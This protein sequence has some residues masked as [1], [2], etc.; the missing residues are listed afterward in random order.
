[1]THNNTDKRGAAESRSLLSELL[2]QLYVSPLRIVIVLTCA[3]MSA[4][5]IG[6]AIFFQF[7]NLSKIE[8]FII[9]VILVVVLLIPA[10]LLFVFKPLVRHKS[11]R[12]QAADDLRESERLLQQIMDFL[13]VGVWIF[14]RQGTVIRANPECSRIWGEVRMVGVD[15]YPE[16]KAWWPE[17]GRL[18][19]PHEWG[20][21]SALQGVASSTNQ[22]I[23]IETFDGKRKTMLNSAT[24][25]KDENGFIIGAVAVINDITE[26]RQ[27]NEQIRKLSQAVEQSPSSIIIT[28][29]KGQIEYANPA[30]TLLTGY[31]NREIIGTTPHILSRDQAS[32]RQYQTIWNAIISGQVWHGEFLNRKKDGSTYWEEVSIAPIASSDG[33]ITHYVAVMEDITRR[34]QAEVELLSSRKRLRALMS[35]LEKAREEERTRIAREVH[36]ELGQ[37]LASVQMGISLLAQEYQ[38]HHALTERITSMEEMLQGAIRSVRQIA[39]EL[40]PM[41]LDTLGLGEAIDWQAREFQKK[42]GIACKP[43]INLKSTKFDRDIS[44]ALFRIFQETLTNII[45]H[46]G[47]TYVGVTLEERKDRLVL[48]VQDN[49][50]GITPKQLKNGSS[51]GIMGMRERAYSLG[52]RVRIVGA[53]RKGTVVIAHIPAVLPGEV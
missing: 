10:L 44:T 12:Q 53:P 30:F 18:L 39:T 40:R 46:S 25:I 31:E 32:Y 33:T 28:D 3:V 26:L 14:D 17:S 1:M 21:V 38:D 16:Y 37:V 22:M 47:A 51:L 24:P 7:E 41:I 13:P 15:R 11:E 5:L 29:L 42:T 43:I 45:R 48:V 49:G 27:A 23:D 34:K 50:R 6:L 19:E 52:G 4:N 35:H 20:V 9:D 8:V 36:D 2:A